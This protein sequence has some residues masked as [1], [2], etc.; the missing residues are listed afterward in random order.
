MNRQKINIISKRKADSMLVD[1]LF[2]P[3]NGKTL[4]KTRW[5]LGKYKPGKYVGREIECGEDVRAIFPQ[6]QRDSDGPYI[7]LYC[8]VSR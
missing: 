1:S 5:D 2:S 8:L 7:A 4:T 6:P 3:V